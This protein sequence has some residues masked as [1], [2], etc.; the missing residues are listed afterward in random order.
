MG[1]RETDGKREERG[2]RRRRIEE[3]TI[4]TGG[5]RGGLIRG[6]DDSIK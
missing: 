2:R 4:E 1:E 5:D 6:T 3:K